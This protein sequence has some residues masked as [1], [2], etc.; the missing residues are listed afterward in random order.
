MRFSDSLFDEQS[1]MIKL[2]LSSQIPHVLDVSDSLSFDNYCGFSVGGHQVELL[3]E[4]TGL[5]SLQLV[6]GRYY[7][8]ECGHSFYSMLV[9]INF[10]HFF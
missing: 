8:F 9:I 7:L 6:E 2:L 3:N 4:V 1:D 5:L 10:T